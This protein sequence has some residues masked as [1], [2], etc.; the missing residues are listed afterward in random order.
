MSDDL[1]LIRRMYGKR[2][3]SVVQ[4]EAGLPGQGIATLPAVT[5][6]LRVLERQVAEQAQKIEDLERR[7]RR[8][9]A[10]IGRLR[11]GSSKS[12]SDIS[13][14]KRSLDSKVDRDW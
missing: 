12:A 2:K 14:V 1:D 9:E 13:E 5:S 11:Q 3:R 6:A 8:Q 10:L 7:C 4:T